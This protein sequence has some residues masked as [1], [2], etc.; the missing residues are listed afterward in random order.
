MSQQSDDDI[1]LRAGEE[2]DIAQMLTD[3]ASERSADLLRSHLE[4]V[5]CVTCGTLTLT[6]PEK[7]N[8]ATCGP[9]LQAKVGA[10]QGEYT[11]GYGTPV[12]YPLTREWHECVSGFEMAE[13]VRR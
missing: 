12:G 4:E 5:P 13:H 3:E 11:G 8:V 9:C 1:V 2:H 6:I 10:G 7:I